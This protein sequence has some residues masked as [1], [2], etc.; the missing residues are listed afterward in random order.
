M[1][2]LAALAVAFLLTY[3]WGYNDDMTMHQ[4]QEKPEKPGEAMVSDKWSILPSISYVDFRYIIF[5]RLQ[6]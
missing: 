4:R 6:E 1:I 3:F 2:T 5:S